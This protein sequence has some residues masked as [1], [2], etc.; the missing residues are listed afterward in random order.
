M[1]NHWREMTAEETKAAKT[2]DRCTCTHKKR[3]H[4]WGGTSHALTKCKVA[5][6]PCERYEGTTD[7]R[8]K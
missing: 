1:T 2:K 6:C 5:L 3:M 8:P 7:V 4:I